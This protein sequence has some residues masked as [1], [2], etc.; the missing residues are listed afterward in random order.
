M[1]HTL[2]AAAEGIV[3][4]P[5]LL[6]LRVVVGVV[7][8]GALGGEKLVEVFAIGLWFIEPLEQPA[9]EVGDDKCQIGS[10]QYQICSIEGNHN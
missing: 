3:F 4:V 1:L 2:P 9:V 8:H 5:V 6:G 10:E 7:A